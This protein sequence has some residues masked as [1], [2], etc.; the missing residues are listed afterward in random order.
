MWDLI[1]LVPEHCFSTLF[2]TRQKADAA[3]GDK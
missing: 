1:Q 3:I 2:I